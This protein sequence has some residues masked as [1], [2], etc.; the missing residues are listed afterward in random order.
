MR[1][2]LI[3]I[4]LL[5]C[6]PLLRAQDSTAWTVDL[7]DVVVTAQYAPTDARSAVHP[8]RT[9]DRQTLDRRF[10]ATAA[11]ALAYDPALRISQDMVLGSALSLLGQDGQG[12]KVLVDGVPVIGRMNG[13]VDLGQLPLHRVERIEIVEGP[14]SVQYGTDALGG[15]VHLI[16]KPSQLRKIESSARTAW[17][18]I[19]EYRADADA[20]VWLHPKLL[21]RAQG[22]ILRFEGFGDP[23]SRDL[24]WNPK[25]QWHAGASAR[26]DAAPGHSLQYRLN[27]LDE[28][29]DNLGIVRRPQ[30]RPY[31]FDDLYATRR[32]D[33][34]L[35]WRGTWK[36]DR[37]HT[38]LI[39]AR[40]AWDRVKERRR[41]DLETGDHLLILGEQDSNRLEAWHLRATVATRLPGAWNGMLGTEVRRDIA[42]GSRIVDPFEDRRGYSH[43]DDIAVFGSIRRKLFRD[44]EAEAGLRWSYNSRFAAPPV[45]SLH[46]R[47]PLAPGLALRASYARGFRAPTT[48]ELY[49]EFVDANHLIFGNPD[50][51]PET[52]DNVQ[53]SLQADGRTGKLQHD[54][55]L[56]AFLNDVRDRIGIYEFYVKDGVRLPA[57]GDTVTLQF[58]HFNAARWKNRGVQ[59]AG[60]S[61][62]GPWT[63]RA[64]ASATAYWQPENA[65]DPGVP[66][67]TWARE[68]SWDASWRWA[69]TGM[70]VSLLGRRFDRLVSFYPEPSGDG[71]MVRRREQAGFSLLDLQLGQPFLNDRLHLKLGVRNLLDIRRTG[72]LDNGAS[73]QHNSGSGDVPVSPGRSF[74]LGVVWKGV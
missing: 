27:I 39:L 33:H 59:L 6:S 49:F 54:W 62:W 45:P 21:V 44:L 55:R 12:V 22:G 48:K 29:I 67:W 17:N 74:V 38:E 20:G 57:Q 40:N 9:L 64:G 5:A 28:H 3:A 41:T 37:L 18:S 10:A 69:R 42:E 32:L 8:V 65:R 2:A 15:V 14:L 60:R 31:A 24:L 1:N 26:F 68:F 11:E 56:T 53:L 51:R 43:I 58:A 70:S 16:T 13:N 34:T 73:L 47:Q 25:D 23:D 72:V 61:S 46:L 50:L 4:L 19:G 35:H 71:T 52:S 7:R 30:F 63:L 66:A 36:E